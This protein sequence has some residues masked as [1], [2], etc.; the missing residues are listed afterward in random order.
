MFQRVAMMDKGKILNKI[1]IDG[2]TF[3]PTRTKA[4]TTC[5]VNCDLR[6]YC[7]LI[8]NK[9]LLEKLT[10]MRTLCY[11]LRDDLDTHFKEMKEPEK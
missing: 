7:V 9:S 11:N 1:R 5:F 2:R 10:N 4:G 8:I 3:A 6:E